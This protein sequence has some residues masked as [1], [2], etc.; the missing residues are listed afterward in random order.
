MS[1][2]QSHYVPPTGTGIVN[3]ARTNSGGNIRM[4][5]NSEANDSI[6]QMKKDNWIAD[7][8]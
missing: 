5:A 4:A 6:D 7:V 2:G 1:G 3:D 8:E